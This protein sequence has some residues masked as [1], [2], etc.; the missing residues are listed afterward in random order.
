MTPESPQSPPA[1]PWRHAIPPARDRLQSRIFVWTLGPILA[2]LCIQAL[3][4]TAAQGRP[5]RILFA[6]AFVISALFALAVWKLR[7]ATGPAALTGG[8]ICLLITFYTGSRAV[9]PFRSGLAPLIELFILT[10]AATRA[11]RLRKQ[12]A[13]LAE[14]R[15]GRTASQILAN[16]GAAAFTTSSAGAFVI[17]AL[18]NLT[19]R[20]V[21]IPIAL[22]VMLLAALTEATA[23]TV[24]SEFGQAFGGQP[25]LITTLRP[26]PPGTDGAITLKGTLAGLLT[27]SLVAA[28]SPWAL[29][30]SPKNTLIALAAG[31]A[32]LFFDSLLGAT[33]ER[34]GWL[35]NDLVNFLSTLFAAAVALAILLAI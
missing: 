17:L 16:L 26:V 19:H 10:F 35:G 28:V 30:T 18:D 20:T 14:P 25:I 27:A 24:S 13:G 5:T 15:R 12:R 7:A 32:G 22:P 23:D 8:A 1:N 31:I 2:L 33:I 6:E 9:S 29:R 4:F 34:R 21:F 11:G 3:T